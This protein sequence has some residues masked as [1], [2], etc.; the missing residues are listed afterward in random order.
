MPVHMDEITLSAKF[1]SKLPKLYYQ[2][3]TNAAEALCVYRENLC[4]MHGHVFLQ[5]LCDLVKKIKGTDF[6]CYKPQFGWPTFS[7]GTVM[8]MVQIVISVTRAFCKR[9]RLCIWYAGK[10][11]P[12]ATWLQNSHYFTQIAAREDARYS[13]LSKCMNLKLNVLF[14]MMVLATVIFTY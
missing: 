6:T 9:C 7:E 2:N 14:N 1:C 8:K 4:Q 11:Y 5:S 10:N 3:G 13:R 12:N